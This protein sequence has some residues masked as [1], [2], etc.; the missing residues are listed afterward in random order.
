MNRFKIMFSNYLV[1][2]YQSVDVL[3]SVEY[4]LADLVVV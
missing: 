1:V 3:L 2:A 4:H